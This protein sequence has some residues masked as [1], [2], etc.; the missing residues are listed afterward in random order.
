MD[1]RRLFAVFHGLSNE[2]VYE[3]GTFAVSDRVRVD[4]HVSIGGSE[5][6]MFDFEAFV[7]LSLKHRRSVAHLDEPVGL[8]KSVVLYEFVEPALY[9]SG[10]VV[11][12]YR[13]RFS[14]DFEFVRKLLE[15]FLRVGE[16]F[17]CFRI[18][19]LDGPEGV[20]FHGS[21][22]LVEIL[23][24]LPYGV[25]MNKSPDVCNETNCPSRNLFSFLRNSKSCHLK[26]LPAFAERIFRVRWQPRMVPGETSPLLR[27]V[28][29]LNRFDVDRFR[30]DL[31]P[32]LKKS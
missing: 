24:S 30:K 15:Y 12:A 22:L 19:S 2:S 6:G 10:D 7:I 5:P 23:F 13:N 29:A 31:E 17:Q 18:F 3:H 28:L 11:T 27:F 25:R 9:E 21:G 26:I 8:E 14:A 4:G 32:I 1:E 20:G 16:I